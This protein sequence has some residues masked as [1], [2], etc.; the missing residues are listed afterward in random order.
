MVATL[1]S[2]IPN[3]TVYRSARAA[4]PLKRQSFK[5]TSDGSSCSLTDSEGA[6]CRWPLLVSLHHCDV[7]HRP[8]VLLFLSF[9]DFSEHRL[10]C[11]EWVKV[12]LLAPFFVKSQ[13]VQN[14]S[15]SIFSLMDKLSMQEW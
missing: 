1:C 5:L 13:F 8:I 9:G 4:R 6:Q 14:D 11:V 10:V 2:L 15:N 12:D 7:T 3:V